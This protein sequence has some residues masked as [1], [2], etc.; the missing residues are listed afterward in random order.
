MEDY[1]HMIIALTFFLVAMEICVIGNRTVYET[2]TQKQVTYN[3]TILFEKSVLGADVF[4]SGVDVLAKLFYPADIT[5]QLCHSD[6]EMETIK[7]GVVGV[8]RLQDIARVSEGKYRTE[9][10]YDNA[11][12]CIC[13]RFVEK[14]E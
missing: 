4:L 12:K 5:I 10:D 6:G 13:L 8:Y 14:T 11:G 9:Y 2:I 1:F 7:K 3:D